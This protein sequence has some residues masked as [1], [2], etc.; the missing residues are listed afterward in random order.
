MKVGVLIFVDFIGEPMQ[1]SKEDDD[2]NDEDDDDHDEECEAE[3]EADGGEE[4]KNEEVNNGDKAEKTTENSGDDGD[5]E[6]N[7]GEETEEVNDL[8][9][10]WEFLELAKLIFQRT[11]DS[12]KEAAVKLSEVHSVSLLVIQGIHCVQHIYFTSSRFIF[13]WERTAWSLRITKLPYRI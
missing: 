4:D 5:D 11:A 12:C 1:E 10:S 2:E 9:L 7:T 8:Q 3:P 6:N 13:Y